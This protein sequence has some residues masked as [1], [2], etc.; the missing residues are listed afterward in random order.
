MRTIRHLVCIG[1]ATAWPLAKATAQC[2]AGEMEVTIDVITDDYGNETYWQLVNYGNTCGQSP[3]FIGGNTNALT[4][5]SAGTQTSPPGGYGNNTTISTGPWCLTEGAQY[6][7]I[8]IDSYG[9]GQ[10]SFNVFANGASIGQFVGTGG[11]NI[12]SFTVQEPALHDMGVT[13]LTTPLFNTVGIA[14][15]FSGTVKNFGGLPV[16]SFTLN[17]S[18]NGSVQFTADI[19]SVNIGSGQSY[20]FMHNGPWTPA[21]A[22]P[23]E[24]EVWANNINGVPDENTANDVRTAQLVVN[25]AIPDIIGNYLALP[26]T[27]V[28][29]ADDDEDLLVPRDLDFHPDRSRNELWVINKDVENTG[30]STVK[31]TAPGEPGQTHLWQRDPNAWHFMSLPTAIAFGD[32]NNFSTSP[33]V[34]DANH[35]GGSPFT[36]ITLWS[37]DPAIYAQ[38]LFGPLGSHLDMLHVTPHAQGIAHER[39]NKFWV[40]DG[41][42][43]D[44]VMH[45]FRGD[46]GPGNDYHGN[47]LIRRYAGMNIQR[48]PNDHIV[49]HCILDKS[50]GW[51]YAV[52]HGGD[53]VIRLNTNTGTVAGNASYLF[54]Q[55]AYVEYTQM[56]GHTWEVVASTG[57]QQ[58]AGIALVGSNLLV[59]DHATG[60]IVVYDISAPSFPELGRISTGAPGIMGIAIGYDGKIWYVN[61]TTHSLVRIDP[62]ANVGIAPSASARPWQ[63]YP[64]PANDRLYLTNTDRLAA[65][66]TW[67]LVDATGRTALNGNANDLRTGID[68]SALGVGTY[69]FLVNVRAERVVITR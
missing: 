56:Q 21:T 31:F 28:V 58:P 22:G 2:N 52:D 17:F 64:N 38:A 5:A 39:W 13:D 48:D 11:F 8:S 29:V 25:D 30:G 24:L 18:L 60:D 19:T 47:A 53:R 10:A 6:S 32:N 34:F 50:T 7:I 44:I 27:V 26:P 51:L 55:E 67:S 16:T 62:D 46:H 35:N 23:V 42:N 40:V 57:L 14:T 33:G 49:S 54:G 61:A 63:V 41:F 66:A 68:I 15:A 36:G 37:S 20:E 69:T 45:D 43:N 12:W 59:S 1:L 4:C 65:G 9:D 3:I